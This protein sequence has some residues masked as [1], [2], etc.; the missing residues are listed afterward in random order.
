[1]KR[2]QYILGAAAIAAVLYSLMFLG[3]VMDDYDQAR[4]FSHA[5]PA[6][7]AKW[8]EWPRKG[9]VPFATDDC[10]SDDCLE[11]RERILIDKLEGGAS[12]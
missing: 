7:P 2:W 12:R 5:D 1:M 3:A 11:T 4:G 9:S 10:A 8:Q 6:D